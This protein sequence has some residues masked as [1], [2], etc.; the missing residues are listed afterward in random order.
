[1]VI[2]NL[3]SKLYSILSTENKQDEFNEW[4]LLGQERDGNFLFSWVQTKENVSS[5]NIGIYNYHANDLRLLYSF[6]RKVNCVQASVNSSKTILAFVTKESKGEGSCEYTYKPFLYEINDEFEKVFDLDIERGKQVMVQFLYPKQSVLSENQPVKLLVF[7]HQEEKQECLYYNSAG[8]RQ[9]KFKITEKLKENTVKYDSLVKTFVWAQWD[10]VQQT[11]YYIHNRKRNRGLVEGE[12]DVIEDTIGTKTT[13]TLSGLQ[14]N[15]E[16]PHETVLNIPLNLPHL[17]SMPGSCAIYEDD[18]VPL[19]I[20]DC[21]LDLVVLTDSNGSLCIC[22]HYL[23]QG[24]F[25]PI[26]PVV[27]LND[28]DTSP[29]HFAYSVTVLHHSCVIH[30]VVPDIPWNRAKK[31]R[32]LFIL[33]GDHLVIFIPEICTHM[34]DVGIMHEPCCHITTSPIITDIETQFLCL[35]PVVSLGLGIT[36]NL[37]TLDLIDANVPATL[38]AETFQSDTL[39]ENKLAILHYFMLHAEDADLTSESDLLP[40]VSPQML[41]EYLIGTS[42][43]SV[44][45]NLPSDASKLINLLPVTSLRI[46]NEL[47][48][49][50]GDQMICLS[51]DV[52]WNASMMLLS[53]QQRIVPYRSDI[54]VKL[55]DQLAK[56]SKGPLRFKPSQVVDKLTVS[57]VCYQPEVL[58]RCSTPMSPSGGASKLNE[59]LGNQTGK[60]NQVDSL[61]FFEVDS[62]TAS[63]QEHIISVN[64][65]ELS[66]HL[67][68]QSSDNKMNRFQW[69]S[70]TPMHVHAVATRYITAQLDQSRQLCQILCKAACYEPRYELDKGFVYINQLSEEMR[71]VLFTILEKYYLAVES[72]AF[73]LPQGF[74]SFF[75]FLGYK[76][77]NFDMFLQ[78]VKRNVFELQV[79][80]M[81]IIMA[82]TDNSK[83]GIQRKLNLLTSLP[84][85]RAKRLLNQWNHPISLMLR[86]REH[87]LNI[88]SGV[89]GPPTSR[90][91]GIQKNKGLTAFPSS[92]HLSPLDTFLDLLTAKATLT[93]IDFGLLVEATETSTEE[94]L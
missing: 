32:P 4:R 13:P 87:S 84:R 92:D 73:P 1:M 8:I 63:K 24:F 51:Q 30:C 50:L 18:T 14:F 40:W 61:P 88:L 82:D 20:H 66:M 74:T 76:T 10:P 5:T 72:I 78:Y 36:I 43:S 33:T 22:H 83:T 9:Y 21:A 44:Q 67:L 71:F 16:V 79:D 80:V 58:S 59:F 29:V 15:D 12:D 35:A 94:F 34:L 65:R 39:L 27:D 25:Q 70:Q 19:R 11:L 23:Y 75:T 93:D 48:V 68:K 85:S 7:I 86:A 37:A 3:S 90:T 91:Q 69:Q 64:L 47:E 45:R 31:M 54:W 38:L 62:C 28:E 60:R 89:A 55:W 57:L 52:L 53:P 41:K 77:L 17:S 49:E 26:Q 81:K 42:Y 56:V 6:D 46:G 2:D